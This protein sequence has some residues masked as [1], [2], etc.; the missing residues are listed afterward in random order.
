MGMKKPRYI[1]DFS[2]T[3]AAAVT[4]DNN[5]DLAFIPRGVYVGTSGHL[6]IH[7]IDGDAVTFNRPNIYP[8]A[9]GG[10]I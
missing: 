7:D 8:H 3:N 9:I 6:A 5:T 2:G 10:G 1:T 4:P